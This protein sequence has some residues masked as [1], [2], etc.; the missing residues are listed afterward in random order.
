MRT[1]YLEIKPFITK[2]NSEIRELMHPNFHGSSKQ[3]FAEATVPV[4][5]ET[6]KHKHI[7]T[8][9]IYYISQ[10]EGMMFLGG[11][12]FEV[13]EGDTICI[14]PGTVHNIKNTGNVPLKIMCCCSPAYSDADTELV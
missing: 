2:D 11:E 13:L 5:S 7:Q 8:E 1:R 4:G 9:E 3:S 12:Q 14:K 10:G 6:A